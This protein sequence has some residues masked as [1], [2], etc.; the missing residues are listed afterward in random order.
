ME[1]T[2]L[3]QAIV[4]SKGIYQPHKERCQEEQKVQLVET[5]IEK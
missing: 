3:Y 2:A 4:D 5:I 1:D